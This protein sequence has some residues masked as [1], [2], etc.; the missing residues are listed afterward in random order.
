MDPSQLVPKLASLMS[1][2]AAIRLEQKTGLKHSKLGSVKNVYRKK[3]GLPKGCSFELV[4]ERLT[5][6]I[7][8]YAN[9]RLLTLP[10]LSSAPEGGN[11]QGNS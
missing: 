10:S 6:E 3:Y 7:E 1:A 4:L 8:E 5:K 2:R 9:G 11:Q